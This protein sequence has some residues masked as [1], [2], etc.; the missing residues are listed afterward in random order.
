MKFSK[1]TEENYGN[2]SI[3]KRKKFDSAFDR[4]GK[5]ACFKINNC[6]N[7]LGNKNDIENE[8][9]KKEGEEVNHFE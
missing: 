8:W 3:K 7:K 5:G 2:V 1:Q 9:R 4:L 6:V